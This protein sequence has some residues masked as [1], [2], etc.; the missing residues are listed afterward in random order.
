M[1][2]SPLGCKVQEYSLRA[3]LAYALNSCC[4]ES[5]IDNRIAVCVSL[6]PFEVEG[7]QTA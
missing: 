1:S 4:R 3:S 2:E 6:E 5:A 7:P